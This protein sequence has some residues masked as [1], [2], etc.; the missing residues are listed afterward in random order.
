[1]SSHAGA[2]MVL[3]ADR[4]PGQTLVL[5]SPWIPPSWA[6]CVRATPW[7]AVLAAGPSMLVEGSLAAIG[8]AVSDPWGIP[9]S[10]LDTHILLDRFA[11]YGDH[12]VQLAA[13]PFA[14][15]DL[16]HGRIAS[17]LNGIVPLF[18]AHGTHTAVG[19]HPAI[20]ATVAAS[21]EMESIPGGAVASVDGSI[22]AVAQIR[23]LESLPLVSLAALEREVEGHIRRSGPVQGFRSSELEHAAPRL[24]IR[25]VGQ[26]LVASPPLRELQ[27]SPCA[28]DD[29][30]ALRSEV[31]RLWWQAGLR[32]RSLF[33]PAFERPA[34]DTLTLAIGGS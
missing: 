28:A 29:L 4:S 30:R 2:L 23:V 1:M 9:G 26:A 17:A 31:N 19:T 16:E 8:T 18:L 32:N 5:A 27:V 25:R 15:A 3:V 33:V 21:P 20:L 22:T 10:T 34:L 7:G 11:R 13:G 24:V 14:V 6:V 12:V